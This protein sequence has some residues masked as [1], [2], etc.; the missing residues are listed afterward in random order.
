MKS[1]AIICARGGSK[2]IPKKNIVNFFGKPMIAWTIEAAISSG[3]FDKVIVSTDDEEIASVSMQFGAEVPFRRTEYADDYSSIS[4][5][6]VD[7]IQILKDRF[8]E[9]YDYV[10]QL[11]PNCP[12]RNSN[13]IIQSY[14]FFVANKL[15]FQISCFEY[16]WMNPWW[17]MK[18]KVD[19]KPELLYPESIKSRSQD[20][21]KLYC[22]TGAIWLAKTSQLIESNNFYGP[23]YRLFPI[24]W[25]SAV[26]IDNY[27]DLEMAR[28]IYLSQ[29]NKVE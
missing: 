11:M 25:Q 9:E 18:M 12:L 20:L 24:S 15:N 7:A 19:N 27:D 3:V 10:A 14:N 1:I 8:N 13:D 26:D 28:A 5:V 22:P 16:G 21:E 4:S 23:D 29:S 17:A 2:R 6:V